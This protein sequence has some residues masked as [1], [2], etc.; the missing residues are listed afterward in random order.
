MQKD[1]YDAVIVGGGVMGSSTA[2]HLMMA[3]RL[4]IAVV[5]KDPTY[6]KASTP[7]SIGNV[8]T[9]FN[10]K[11]NIQI[12]QYAY[13]FMEQFEEIMAVND[14]KPH[15]SWHREGNLFFVDPKIK[16]KQKMKWPCKK[17]SVVMWNSGVRKNWKCDCP[18]AI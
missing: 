13:E 12:S 1:T 18:N 6:A 4:K 10:L 8:R 7:L 14:I 9:Q 15:I 3:D 2:Y 16:K 5:E 17:V 11:E